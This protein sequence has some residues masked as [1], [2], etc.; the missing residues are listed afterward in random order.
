MPILDTG[1]ARIY[2]L[3]DGP[4]GPPVVFVNTWTASR[5]YWEPLIARLRRSFRCVSFDQRGTGRSLAISYQAGFDV[6]EM[7]DDLHALV[8]RSGSDD[9]HLVGHG[10]GGVVAALAARRHPQ[11]FRTLTLIGP[12]ILPVMEDGIEGKVEEFNAILTQ[13]RVMMQEA[14]M[15]PVARTVLLWRYRT[16]PE[17]YRTRLYED[18]AA[19]DPVAAYV[20]ARSAAA[21]ETRRRF[22]AALSELPLPVLLVRGEKDDVVS[23]SVLR[24]FF[25]HIRRGQ[26]ATVRGSGHL[27]MLE[28]PDEL[29]TLLDDF[30][31]HESPVRHLAE[32]V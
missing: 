8:R 10:L 9:A 29:A 24:R 32:R 5:V 1:T 18:F 30:F 12:D 26:L 25:D 20:T 27:P 22:E 17:P 3:T 23:D 2:Y 4:E 15:W 7:V 14:A 28:F 11:D 31:R 16:A 21:Y 19:A 13:A 6:D